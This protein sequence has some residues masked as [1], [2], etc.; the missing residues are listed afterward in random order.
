MMVRRC[1]RLRISIEFK[2]GLL[3]YV[4]E[5]ILLTTAKLRFAAP[6]MSH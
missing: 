1:E 2:R 5:A 3:E 4:E 6:D